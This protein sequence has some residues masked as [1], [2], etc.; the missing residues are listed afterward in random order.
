[1]SDPTA[2]L[3]AA[4]RLA[5]AGQIADADA[6]LRDVLADD[7]DNASALFLLGDA[8][9]LSGRVA[10]ASALLRRAV[11]LRPQHRD[12]RL[13]LVRALLAAGQA[14]NALVSLA[15]LADD[16][17]L[18]PA[19]SL[20][21]SALAMMGQAQ[22]A[23][24]AFSLALATL[25]AD[26]EIHL[27]LGNCLADLDDLVLAERHIRRAIALQP[28][29][30]EAHVSLGHILIQAGRAAE[31]VAACDAAIALRPDLP[32]AHWNQ[33]V[34]LLLDGDWTAGWDKYE[35]RKRHYP[36]SFTSL[37]GP[38][39]DGHAPLA[40]RTILV[41]A[42]QGFGDTIQFARYLPLLARRGATVV[43]ECA[44]SLTGLMA[45]QRGVSAACARG[46]R[47]PYDYW[48][49]QMSL[50]RLF[51]TRPDNV[52]YSSGY[53]T[54]DPAAAARW[55]E[56][57]PTGLRAGLVW[58]G[59]SRHSND[60]RRSMPA[61]SLAPIIAAGRDAVVSLQA[62][63]RARDLPQLY[64]LQDYSSRLTDWRETAAAISV[65]DLVIT[66][67]TAVAHLAGALGI[68]AWVMLPHAP[69]WRWMLDRADTPWYR[70]MRLFRQPT[71]GDWASVVDRVA[72][73]LAA[74]TRP[75]YSM[76][77]PPLTWSVAPVTHAAS[78]DAR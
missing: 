36:G 11:D 71:P 20:R 1:M 59:N 61:A 10:E 50:P 56:A 35:W 4:I 2:D 9:L 60:R 8:A 17:A 40:G 24:A 46:R 52:P 33:G 62:G 43:V 37:P 27:N 51:G 12:S 23:A 63:P 7:P 41:V 72:A 34:A 47:P 19:Q 69:D 30:A 44:A 14:D 26:A 42:E 55:E 38:H 31:A 54:A 58:A 70:S 73:E 13:A 16:P 74:M 29:L 78:S 22:A 64:G 76:A 57:L 75:A 32:A 18:G 66:V 65:L 15:P 6:L 28:T 21:G 3:L 68:P 67:D 53:I 77:I 25:P 49:D 48:A 39:W 5:R 45:S